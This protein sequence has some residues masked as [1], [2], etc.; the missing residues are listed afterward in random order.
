M[1][2]WS[3]QSTPFPFSQRGVGG[4]TPP[5][6]VALDPRGLVPVNR[7]QP[8]ATDGNEAQ[9]LMERRLGS[10]PPSAFSGAGAGFVPPGAGIPRNFAETLTDA[11]NA[12][13]SIQ[14]TAPTP[15]LSSTAI[16]RANN[17]QVMAMP[18]LATVAPERITPTNRLNRRRQMMRDAMTR[19]I[20]QTGLLS[21]QGL[22]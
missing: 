13:A 22:R 15:P 8:L 14:P 10:S 19:G 7:S 18:R 3:R 5:T 2:Q 21:P 11:G 1:E 16:A 20:P 9:R 17:A 12:P 4:G 6:P